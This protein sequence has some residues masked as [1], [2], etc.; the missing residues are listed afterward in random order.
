MFKYLVNN[1]S[2]VCL[3][4]PQ[5]KEIMENLKII[6][7]LFILMYILLHNLGMLK[8]SITFKPFVIDDKDALLD[9]ILSLI[10]LSATII[11]LLENINL[12]NF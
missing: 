12:I 1:K 5:N 10:G 4:N 3:F 9:V 2:R 7:I 6:L 11:I 8:D